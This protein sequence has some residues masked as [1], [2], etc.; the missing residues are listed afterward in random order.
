MDFLTRLK[1]SKL[2]QWGVAYLGAAWLLLQLLSLLAQPFGLPGLVMRA[3][4]VLLG[5]GFFAVLV[6]AWY[7]GE[8][9]QQ[10]AAGVE[11]LMLAGILV[12]AG[13]AVSVVAP[14]APTARADAPDLSAPSSP[15]RKVDARSI[16][17]LPFVDMSPARD[18]AYFSDGITEELLNTL[19]RVAGLKVAARTSSFSFKGRNVPVDEIGKRLGV[20][21]VLEGSVQ[22]DGDRLRITAQLVNAQTGYHVWSARYD[23]EAGDIF[24]L[25]D[26]ISRAITQALEV[27]LAG[28]EPIARS[29]PS[30]IEVHDLYLL[31]LYQL[32]QRSEASLRKAVEHFEEATA[33]DPRYARAYAGLA[34]AYHLL[35]WYSGSIAPK[36]SASRAQTA[37]Q[38]AL[39]FDPDLAEAHAALGV[40]RAVYFWDWAGAEQEFKRAIVLNPNLATAH[41]WYAEH[42]ARHHRF[43]EALRQ[44]RRAM[45]LDPLSL[46][47]NQSEAFTL[48]QAR[49]Y[50]A[51]IARFRRTLELNPDFFLPHVHLGFIYAL[52]GDPKRAVAESRL[53]V[54]TAGEFGVAQ[55]GLAYA[56]A[57]AGETVEARRILQRLERDAATGDGVVRLADIARVHV[58]LG[59]F[60]AAISRLQQS[61]QVQ[62]WGLVFVRA[63][64]T[65]DPLR[66]DPRFKAVLERMGRS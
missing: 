35:P 58:A 50:D 38:K 28:L 46:A 14:G 6:L 25:E 52:Q 18:Q 55:A 64:P 45:E 13:A 1:E 66:A 39:T 53:A 19:A 3:T 49:R 41:H 44:N 54:A 12:V 4:T 8:R 65:F 27:Q 36:E 34:M 40:L 22:R 47:V 9:G 61:L 56:L 62:D 30:S 59:D 21:H 23:R 5:M 57:R 7:H 32:N 48:Y 26:E 37:A 31:G 43:E 29:A 42:L 24:A 20:A 51:A 17:V 15:A 33:R 11:L 2:G 10:K 60:D 63:D 16:A